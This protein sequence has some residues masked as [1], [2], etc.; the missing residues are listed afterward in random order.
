MSLLFIRFCVNYVP[1]H[2]F[3]LNG[4]E[5]IINMDS[6]LGSLMLALFFICVLWNMGNEYTGN[7]GS[8][9]LCIFG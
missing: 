4:R 3:G 1:H 7:E 5:S 8:N 2:G 9:F 6:L